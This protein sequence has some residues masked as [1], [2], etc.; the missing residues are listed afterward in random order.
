[1]SH[2]WQEHRAVTSCLSECMVSSPAHDSLVIYIAG[3][4]VGLQGAITR[5]PVWSQC[6]HYVAVD[7]FHRWS[8]NDRALATFPVDLKTHLVLLRKYVSRHSYGKGKALLEALGLTE[9]QIAKY[10]GNSPLNE[11]EAVQDGLKAWI[12]GSLD[13]TWSDLLEAMETAG[14]DIQQREG[15]KEELCVNAGT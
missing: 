1:M 10:Y 9:A 7:P 2:C 3:M 5:V 4:V 14:I 15:L 12:G 11:E 6:T 8:M 13:S